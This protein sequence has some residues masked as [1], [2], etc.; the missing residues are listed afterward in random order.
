MMY[1]KLVSLN[2]DKY[3]EILPIDAVMGYATYLLYC[4]KAGY[5]LTDTSKVYTFSEWLKYEI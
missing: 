4:N 1:K 2:P 5:D 3:K